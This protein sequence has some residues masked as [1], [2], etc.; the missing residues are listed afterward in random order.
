MKLLNLR[1]GGRLKLGIRIPFTTTSVNPREQ[2]Q[3]LNNGSGDIPSEYGNIY[4][5]SITLLGKST[6]HFEI[7]GLSFN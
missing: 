3:T 6:F 4:K 1:S 5:I 7:C 2:E